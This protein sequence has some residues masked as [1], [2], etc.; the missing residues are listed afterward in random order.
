MLVIARAPVALTWCGALKRLLQTRDDPPRSSLRF[1]PRRRGVPCGSRNTMKHAHGKINI[2]KIKTKNAPPVALTWTTLA[3][4]AGPEAPAIY[5]R[6][7]GQRFLARRKAAVSPINYAW[8]TKYIAIDTPWKIC[9]YNKYCVKN[10][11]F[12]IANWTMNIRINHWI[13]RTITIQSVEAAYD[14]QKNVL[15]KHGSLSRQ[16]TMNC[17]S[18]TRQGTMNYG[19]LTLQGTMNRVFFCW[20]GP[21]GSRGIAKKIPLPSKIL[22][23]GSKSPPTV[24]RPG[25]DGGGLQ[26]I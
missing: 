19:S 1:C 11:H 20:G 7:W 23:R 13:L 6:H 24:S 14:S 22:S 8:Y 4:A 17:S 25:G 2:I 9:S 26:N 12:V 18:L 10:S 16:G 5:L 21:S 15:G 3:K